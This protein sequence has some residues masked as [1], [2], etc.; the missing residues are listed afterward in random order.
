MKFSYVF[1]WFLLF[2]CTVGYTQGTTENQRDSSIQDSPESLQ[3][4]MA[5]WL[6]LESQKGLL[7][8]NWAARNQQIHQKLDLFEKESSVLQ[9]VLADAKTEKTDVDQ[10]RG[11]LMQ[12]Q[13]ALE[14][15][16]AEMDVQLQRAIANL[17]TL[18]PRLPPPLQAQWREKMALLDQDN[19]SNSEKLERV[20]SLL[21]LVGDFNH[22]V[23][24]HRGALVIP[25]VDSAPQNIL[26]NQIY[27]GAGHGWYVSDDGEFYGYGKAEALGWRWWHGD[28]ASVYLGSTLEAN[29]VLRILAVL[30]KPTDA[31]YLPL[32]IKLH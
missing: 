25:A 14:A 19:V 20:L 31:S 22:R 13:I 8:N 28:A 1:V 3:E 12:S 24:L 30:Q 21:K 23:A 6:R 10:R 16:Q 17:K 27:V 7:Q 2:F 11:E 15:E 4:L 26:V 32:P 29:D 9:Q 5:Q 18:I